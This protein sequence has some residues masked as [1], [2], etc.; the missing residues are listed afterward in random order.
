MAAAQTLAAVDIPGIHHSPTVEDFADSRNVY[1]SPLLNLSVVFVLA[2]TRF[3][4]PM[5]FPSLRIS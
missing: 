5:I 1:V 2:L 3:A 4:A